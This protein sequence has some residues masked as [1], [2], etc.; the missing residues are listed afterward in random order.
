MTRFS[1]FLT[2]VH[3]DA[4]VNEIRDYES[5]KTERDF[6]GVKKAAAANAKYV[7]TAKGFLTY[8]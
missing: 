2:K 6:A 5:K 4:R 3:D 7:S 8:A 1:D